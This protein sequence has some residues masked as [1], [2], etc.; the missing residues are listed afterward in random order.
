MKYGNEEAANALLKE[1]ELHPRKALVKITS[2]KKKPK[3]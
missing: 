1:Q 2:S 3:L